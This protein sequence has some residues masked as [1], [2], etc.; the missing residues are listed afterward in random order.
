MYRSFVIHQGE[1]ICQLFWRPNRI[2]PANSVSLFAA[3]W[4]SIMPVLVV[5]ESFEEFSL[6]II[7]GWVVD[8]LVGG[9]PLDR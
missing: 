8:G 5:E 6:N 3:L 7:L 4:M 1:Y 9:V 2:L